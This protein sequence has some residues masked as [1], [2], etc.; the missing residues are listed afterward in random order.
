MPHEN[1][2]QTSLSRRIHDL[3]NA[4]DQVGAV[5]DLTQDA[6]LHVIDDQSHALGMTDILQALRKRHPV[7]VLHI[8]APIP[9]GQDRRLRRM[10]AC[11]V[12]W[13]R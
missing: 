9:S 11:H 8:K 10:F 13:G 4:P 6:D 12:G 7:Y 2:A 5:L 3:E 1:D